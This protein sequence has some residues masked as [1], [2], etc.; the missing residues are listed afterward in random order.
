MSPAGALWNTV[1]L[2]PRLKLSITKIETALFST[3][4][5]KYG[6]QRTPAL[7]VRRLD[8]RHE[9]WPYSPTYQLSMCRMLGPPC[10]RVVMR[11][12]MKSARPSPVARP[13]TVQVPPV[14][15]DEV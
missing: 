8:T 7:T 4:C 2:T 12:T 5:P 9:S 3:F 6:S 11:P 14:R 1:L 13:S 15:D 10:S